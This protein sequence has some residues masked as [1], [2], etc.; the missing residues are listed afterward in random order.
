MYTPYSKRPTS[1]SSQHVSPMKSP[2][3]S[4]PP[5]EIHD[6]ASP[7]RARFVIPNSYVHR[8]RIR[9]RFRITIIAIRFLARVMVF[10]R[11]HR[12][13]SLD[14]EWALA[15]STPARTPHGVQKTLKALGVEVTEKEVIGMAGPPT[16]PYKP[17]KVRETIRW[18]HNQRI[19][20]ATPTRT[21]VSTRPRTAPPPEVPIPCV[22]KLRNHLATAAAHEKKSKQN[23][24]NAFFRNY[25]AGRVYQVNSS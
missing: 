22:E 14:R 2:L 6:Y 9:R 7:H 16:T 1:S 24:E 10:L 23:T 17:H 5:H 12:P 4:P 21:V 3:R 8:R 15:S 25:Y 13:M 20:S 18:Y 11:R 19:L